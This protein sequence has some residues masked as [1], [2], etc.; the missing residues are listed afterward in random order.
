MTDESKSVTGSDV[1]DVTSGALGDT[2]VAWLERCAAQSIQP[3]VTATTESVTLRAGAHATKVACTPESMKAA[4]LPFKADAR[5]NVSGIKHAGYTDAV[6]RL[7]EQIPGHVKRV[8][9]TRGKAQ[10]E[11]NTATVVLGSVAKA[12]AAYDKA[13][14]KTAKAKSAWK[15]A[16]QAEQA[17]F[18]AISD[19]EQTEKILKLEQAKA[20]Q[21]KHDKAIEQAKLNKAALQAK[22]EKMRAE[23]AKLE[24]LLRDAEQAA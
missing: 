23:Q 11:G 21:A 8:V 9:A 7:N 17:A 16:E 18:A 19:A 5:W 13:A 20:E 4:L 24:K 10:T 12:K 6:Y 2:I 22:L 14:D 15:R 3:R 1:T